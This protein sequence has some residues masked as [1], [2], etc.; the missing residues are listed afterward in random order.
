[1]LYA[2]LGIGDVVIVTPVLNTSPL[3]ALGLTFLFAREGELFDW[4][5]VAGTVAIVAGVAIL[6][7]V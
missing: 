6:S 5:V 3:F 2:A 7:V 1:M 4:R